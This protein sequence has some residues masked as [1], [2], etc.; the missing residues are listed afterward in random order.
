M[1]NPDTCLFHAC[2]VLY[3][4]GPQK[5][6][7]TQAAETSPR[8]PMVELK[9]RRF[10]SSQLGR[11]KPRPHPLAPGSSCLRSSKWASPS[12]ISESGTT[13][14]RCYLSPIIFSCG[15]SSLVVTVI[16]IAFSPAMPL[17]LP[18]CLLQDVMDNCNSQL[19]LRTPD[20]IP[21]QPSC[22]RREAGDS[23]SD[24]VMFLIITML[25]VS[26]VHLCS[27]MNS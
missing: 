7:K 25:L 18:I 16:I 27:V 10:P 1:Q 9:V 4:I 5:K 14:F 11:S 13:W 19:H 15:G 23:V 6:Q 2:S 8:P 3:T 26:Q 21:A 24:T 17:S 22:Q 20:D 12:I